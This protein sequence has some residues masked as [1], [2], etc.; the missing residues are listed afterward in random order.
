[1]HALKKRV[2]SRS[3]FRLGPTEKADARSALVLLAGSGLTLTE[4]ARRALLAREPR[5]KII[6]R[7]PVEDAVRGFIADRHRRQR[8]GATLEYY[9]TQLSRLVAAPFAESWQTITRPELKK[10]LEGLPGALSTRSMVFRS[11]RSLYRWAAQQDPP[12]VGDVP[13]E[14]LVLADTGGDRKAV[15]FYSVEICAGTLGRV[16]PAALPALALHIFAGVRPE[17]IAPRFPGKARLAWESLDFDARVVRVPAEVAKTRRSRL[18][19]ELPTPLWE[20]LGRVPVAE[21]AG[22]IWA[23]GPEYWRQRMREALGGSPWVVDGFRHTFATMCLALTKDAGQVAEW[24]GHEGKLGTLRNR[25]VG[26]ERRVN[27]DVFMGL[28]RPWVGRE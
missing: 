14:G 9:E 5:G 13:T 1:M 15:G 3:D 11:V 8:R 19:E 6:K 4:A 26:L 24:M 12:L 10:W 21:R 2:N 20:W 7:V 28:G 22:P 17:E 18:I 16:V 27:A 23:L 25:Y